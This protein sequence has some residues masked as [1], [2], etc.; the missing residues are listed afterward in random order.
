[1][2]AVSLSSSKSKLFLLQTHIANKQMSADVLRRYRVQAGSRW[3]SLQ[4]AQILAMIAGTYPDDIGRSL[5][6]MTA[7]NRCAC[8]YWDLDHQ[9]VASVV[10]AVVADLAG[11]DARPEQNRR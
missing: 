3:P 7:Q 5:P 2:S 4:Q 10:V 1:M 9:T 8:P 6:R 11:T